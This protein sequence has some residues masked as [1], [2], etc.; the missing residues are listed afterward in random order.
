[1]LTMMHSININRN[2]II[3]VEAENEHFEIS[4]SI[5]SWI[6]NC[7]S[8]SSTSSEL[9]VIT[10]ASD[11]RIS[12]NIDSL[13]ALKGNCESLR[14]I[15]SSQ[16]TH[17]QLSATGLAW[18]L[19]KMF[20]DKSGLS[21]SISEHLTTH[22]LYGQ[23]QDCD[24]TNLALV[25]VQQ[26]LSDLDSPEVNSDEQNIRV[27]SPDISA[28]DGGNMPTLNDEGLSSQNVRMRGNDE[29]APPR[30][31]IIFIVHDEPSFRKSMQRQ[32]Y[33]CAGCGTKI[34][35]ELARRLVLYCH[36][37]GKYFCKCCFSHKSIHLPGYILQKWDFHKYPVS[38]FA[39]QLLDR[40]SNEPLFNINDINP[41]LYRKVKKLRSLVDIRMQLYYLKIYITTCA[42]TGTLND[43]YTSFSHQ[44][45]IQD[46]L[47]SYSLNNL[48]E[49][50]LGKLYEYLED[51]VTRSIAHIANCDRCRAKGH[52]CQLCGPSSLMSSMILSGGG[53]S[54]QSAATKLKTSSSV[55]HIIDTTSNLMTKTSSETPNRQLESHSRQSSGNYIGLTACISSQANSGSSAGDERQLIFPFEIGRVAQCRACGCCFHLQCFLQS[56]QKCPK[57]E[58]IQRRRAQADPLDTSR[59][60]TSHFNTENLNDSPS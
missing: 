34:D 4:D 35:L 22:K 27:I 23:S 30:A 3:N 41:S 25:E 28:V 13:G 1:M 56:D 12:A 8:S 50:Q 38:Y 53:T 49:I 43:E 36:Y 47:H 40:I 45:L 15:L 16:I 7:K 29:W 32:N 9:D 33:L 19:V 52:Y 54:D 24:E 42:Q 17:H 20:S 14:N 26:T 31:Q 59:K 21:S 39:L 10:G 46:D 11:L 60:Q 55:G 6:E 51:L 57:C 5:I 37:F 58:R 48:I 44:Y 2:P 18:N